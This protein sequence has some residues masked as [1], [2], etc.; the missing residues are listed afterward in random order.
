MIDEELMGKFLEED[1]DEKL[2]RLAIRTEKDEET[3][4]FLKQLEQ[5]RGL[6]ETEG[7]HTGLCLS[8]LGTDFEIGYKLDGY[9]GIMHQIDADMPV[10]IPCYH[11]KNRDD[12][13]NF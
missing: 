9:E 3:E 2:E 10:L 5:A 12:E 7:K 1:E 6:I 13:F 4:S 8:C 11:G